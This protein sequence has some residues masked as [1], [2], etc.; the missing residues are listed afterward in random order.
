MT[1]V[2][3]KNSQIFCLTNIKEYMAWTVFCEGKNLCLAMWVIPWGQQ[4]YQT[5][6]RFFHLKIVVSES[7]C[8]RLFFR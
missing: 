4:E 6:F 1:F 3:A 7:I 8:K 2:A 5:Q